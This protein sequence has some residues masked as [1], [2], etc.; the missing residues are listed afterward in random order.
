MRATITISNDIAPG[1]RNN[2]LS[3]ADECS[4]MR[5]QVDTDSE[6][7]NPSLDSALIENQ[8]QNS[9][10]VIKKS[11]R[12][13]VSPKD[14]KPQ[15][16][17]QRSNSFRNNKASK[18]A[19]RNAARVRKKLG[20]LSIAIPVVGFIAA[21]ASLMLFLSNFTTGGDLARGTDDEATEYAALSDFGF[22]AFIIVSLFFQYYSKVPMHVPGCC[23]RFTCDTST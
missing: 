10:N 20:F 7:K 2:G 15:S 22:Y 5:L 4:E 14:K 16:S 3:K 17:V 23:R 9:K 21:L 11:P 19:R 8:S 18:K 13:P 6:Q 1:S 12:S